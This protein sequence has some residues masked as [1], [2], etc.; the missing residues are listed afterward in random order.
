[1]SHPACIPRPPSFPQLHILP[2]ARSA[3]QAPLSPV[4]LSSV[5]GWVGGRPP[6]LQRTQARPDSHTIQSPTR[7]F[8]A[9][10]QLL[11]YLPTKKISPVPSSVHSS[12]YKGTPEAQRPQQPRLGAGCTG[13]STPFRAPLRDARPSHWKCP[14]RGRSEGHRDNSH[15][16][17]EVNRGMPWGW[18]HPRDFFLLC[19]SLAK[20]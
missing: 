19:Q 17:W 10:L 3:A 20:R 5:L 1:M 2:G 4:T 15:L 7:L 8:R 9:S 6:S 12:S 16:E 11:K 18:S 14:P 13:A